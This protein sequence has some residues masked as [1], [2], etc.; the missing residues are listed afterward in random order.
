M[1]AMLDTAAVSG[2]L[3]EARAPENLAMAW[4]DPILEVYPGAAWTF[5]S[6]L[7][8]CARSPRTSG[9]SARRVSFPATESARRPRWSL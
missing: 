6:L 7:P 1:T 4:L 8:A 9:R 2:E 3:Q 5:L